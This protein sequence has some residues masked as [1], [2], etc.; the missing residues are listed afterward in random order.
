MPLWRDRWTM[1]PW[2]IVTIRLEYG[3]MYLYISHV[4]ITCEKI[5]GELND[6]VVLFVRWW[7]KKKNEAKEWEHGISMKGQ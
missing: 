4:L 2:R 6:A 1:V 7:D 5:C 3:E